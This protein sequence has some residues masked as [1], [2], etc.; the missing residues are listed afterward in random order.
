MNFL[1]ALSAWHFAAAGLV[2]AAGPIVI[3]LL[4]RRRPRTVHWAAMDFLREA[5]QRHRRLIQIRDLVLLALRTIAVLLF[6]L[7]LARPYFSSSSQ[8]FDGTQPLHAVLLIDNSLSMGYQTVGGTLLEQAKTTAREFIDRLPKGSQTSVVPL[9][10]AAHGY[11]LDPY[12]SKEDATDAVNRIQ[13]VDRSASFRR[14]LN[15]ARKA[16]ESAPQLAKR[17]VLIGDQQGRN[18]VDVNAELLAELPS[19]QVVTVSSP[20]RENTW[21][22]S[23]RVRGDVAAVNLESTLIAEVRHQG[24]HPRRD[25]PVSL[26]VD[27]RP[28]ATQ[29]VTVA[30]GDAGREVVFQFNFQDYQPDADRPVFVPVH[31]ALAPDDL[32]DDDQR[33]LVVPIVAELPVVFIDQYADEDEDPALRRFGETRFL[34]TLLSDATRPD[35]SLPSLV[36][37]RHV[38]IEALGRDALA[39]ARLAVVAGVRSPPP[40]KVDLLREYVEQGGQLILA[41]GGDFDPAAWTDVAWRDGQGLLPG[42]LEPEPV[43]ILPELATSTLNPFQLSFESLR[44][45][46][47]RL[48]DMSEDDQRQLYDEPLFFQVVQTD[49][50]DA[51]MKSLRERELRWLKEQSQTPG[52]GAQPDSEAAANATSNDT[53]SASSNV[54]S[55]DEEVAARQAQLESQASERLPRVL[56]GLGNSQRTPLL[57]DRRAGRGRIVFFASGIFSSWNTLPDSAAMFVFERF[58]REMISATLP[59]TNFTTLDQVKVALPDVDPGSRVQLLRPDQPGRPVPLDVSFIDAQ[60]RGV[61]VANGVARGIYMLQIGEEATPG[62]STPRPSQSGAADGASGESAKG[63]SEASTVGNGLTPSDAARDDAG[64]RRT[65]PLALNGPADESDLAPLPGE[66]QERLEQQAS[67]SWLAPGQAIS[68]DG[69]QLRGQNSWWYLVVVVLMLLGIEMILLARISAQTS[70]PASS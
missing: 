9:C 4:N 26:W 70:V 45:E 50:S 58:T 25:V 19:V 6:G 28:V 56:A 64:P 35:P 49:L 24:D 38:T 37:V 39:D 48:A 66:R 32:P 61:S 62:L 16:C 46:Y 1:P 15:D 60:R 44:D 12:F 7:A 41:A 54:P 27:G 65:F 55:N 34:R 43:G 68:L 13:I 18:W 23:L 29:T 53:S 57:I 5:L 20:R 11:T 36:R 42:P 22:S 14:A 8:Q 21:V 33:F 47:F 17:L 67:L 2:C 63:A 30:P 52:E 3:H 51:V 40:D 69:A 10:G 59:A 31:V